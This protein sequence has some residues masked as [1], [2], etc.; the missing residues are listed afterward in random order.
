M[1]IDMI[2]EYPPLLGFCTWLVIWFYAFFVLHCTHRLSNYL[3]WSER[4]TKMLLKGINYSHNIWPYMFSIEK[5]LRFLRFFWTFV[6]IFYMIRGNEYLNQ[7]SFQEL[8]YLESALHTSMSFHDIRDCSK[9]LGDGK[10]KRNLAL[11]SIAQAILYGLC[12]LILISTFSLVSSFNF[13]Y[14]PKVWILCSISG[15]LLMSFLN[16]LNNVV[17]PILLYLV[18]REMAVLMDNPTKSPSVQLFWLKWNLMVQKQLKRS[19]FNPLHKGLKINR[20]LASLLTFLASGIFHAYPLSVA[21]CS[22]YDIGSM[23]CYFAIQLVC[24]TAERSLFKAFSFSKH[25][26]S[27]WMWSCV[28]GFSPLFMLPVFSVLDIQV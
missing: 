15:F 13:P 10:Q 3:G 16:F 21:G 6:S 23:M 9:Y 25:A 2:Y 17:N 26:K 4:N 19:V 1:N 8:S 24:I 12:C 7:D 28:I 22:F 18:N 5:E 20:Q 27:A 14:F 11:K